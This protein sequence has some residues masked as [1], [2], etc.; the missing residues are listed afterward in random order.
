MLS[1]TELLDAIW[2]RVMTNRASQLQ[3]AQKQARDSLKWTSYC[4]TKLAYGRK[5]A[6]SNR[7]SLLLKLLIMLTALFIQVQ[8]ASPTEGRV[9]QSDGLIYLVNTTTTAC[10]CGRYQRDGVPCSHAMAFI[11]AQGESL[12]GYLPASMSIAN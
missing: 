4:Q 12:E 7:V 10:G 5:W 11:F 1:I 2:H 3:E 6:Q 8:H 9:I